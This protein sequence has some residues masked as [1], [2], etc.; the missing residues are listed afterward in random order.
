MKTLARIDTTA[1]C[2]NQ[3]CAAPRGDPK[4]C[5]GISTKR[6]PVTSLK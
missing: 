3:H 2:P 4:T 1:M 5:N 6:K